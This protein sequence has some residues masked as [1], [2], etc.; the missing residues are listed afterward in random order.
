M[1]ECTVPGMSDKQAS[2]L[3]NLLQKQLSAYSDLHL[4]LKHI[5]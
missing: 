1:P 2:A 5:H 4:T 3:I